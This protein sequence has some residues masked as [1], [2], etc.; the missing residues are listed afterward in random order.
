MSEFEYIKLAHEVKDAKDIADIGSYIDALESLAQQGRWYDVDQ[1]IGEILKK[2]KEEAN[3]Y[4]KG[5]T[6]AQTPQDAASACYQ[7]L[8]KLRGEK[9]AKKVAE[10]LAE[11]TV[12]HTGG[13]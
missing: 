12:K 11:E 2:Y 10:K 9:V 3:Q 1:L 7:F 5:R 6:P 8:T 13:T 4:N